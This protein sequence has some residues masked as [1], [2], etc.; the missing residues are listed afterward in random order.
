MRVVD[1]LPCR[2]IW[3]ILFSSGGTLLAI[4]HVTRGV[5]L[6]CLEFLVCSDAASV[7][8]MLAGVHWMGYCFGCRRVIGRVYSSGYLPPHLPF[9]RY[10]VAG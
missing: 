10:Y 4:C 6:S 5:H 9:Y 8:G 1:Q 7:L 3:I 2:A